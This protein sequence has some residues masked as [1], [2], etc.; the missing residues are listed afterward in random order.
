[1]GHSANCVPNTFKMKSKNSLDPFTPSTQQYKYIPEW[2][3]FL[4]LFPHRGSF[5]W[6]LHP[7]DGEKPEWRTETRHLLSDRMIQQGAYLY[8]VR[9]GS[10]TNYLMIDLDRNSRYHPFRDPLA[11]NRILEALEPLGLYS[12]CGVTSSYS[13]GFHLYFPFALAVPSWKIAQAA[14]ALLESK[15]IVCDRGQLELF[16]NARKGAGA[17]FNG[18]R[19]PLQG[20]GSYLVNASFNTVYGGRE[21]FVQRWR[22]AS[23]RNE[24]PT[25]KQL[26]QILKTYKRSAPRRLSTD[27]Q[28]FLADLNADIEPGWSGYGQTNR[29]V[30]RVAL[31]EY[32]FGHFL[33]GRSEPLT[34]LDLEFRI[35]QVVTSLPGYKDWCRHQH[36]IHVLAVYAARSVELSDYYPYK[37][38]AEK[39]EHEKQHYQN[40]WNLLQS[41]RARERIKAAVAD[42]IANAQPLMTVRDWVTALIDRIKCS[43]TTLYKYRE[44]WHPKTLEPSNDALLHPVLEDPPDPRSLE[45]SNDALLHP[46]QPNKLS[47]LSDCTPPECESEGTNDPAI[48]GSKGGFPQGE[49]TREAAQGISFVNKIL[50]RIRGEKEKPKGETPPHG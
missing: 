29:I 48:G 10:T 27:A 2:D 25:E 45:P 21:E 44:L 40:Q 35:L 3:D 24:T 4:A 49:L 46:T 7:K 34:G 6:A 12:Y 9:F 19:L 16:P 14:E 17:D 8:G 20:A 11:I 33:T 31:R 43:L 5:L 13:G 32:I 50:Q 36:E 47:S 30:C 28:K 23:S 18:H 39:L 42:L 41:D 1:M 15:G 22:F 38:K 26:D 37:G